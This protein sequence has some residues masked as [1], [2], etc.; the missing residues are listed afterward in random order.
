MWRSPNEVKR[1][2]VHFIIL[3]VL[4]AYAIINRAVDQKVATMSLMGLLLFFLALEYL[5][6]ERGM[7]IPI[8]SKI[9][10]P[11][12]KDR[13]SSVI[14]FMTATVI[15]LA[16]FRFEVALAALLMTTF[17]DMAAAIIGRKYGVT[18]IYRNKTL[19]GSVSELIINLLIAF[20]V[21]IT[22]TNIYVIIITAFTATIVEI[23]A[24]D[25][26][27]NL[28]GPLFAGFVGQLMIILI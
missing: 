4:I 17:G 11:Q 10:I 24:D 2:A 28:L 8:Y 16:V 25:M 18:L 5:R 7:E 21:L 14:F 22:I 19:V 15:C 1:R 12:E 27:D 13:L 3:F 20:L 26:D 6:I 23:L 9:V